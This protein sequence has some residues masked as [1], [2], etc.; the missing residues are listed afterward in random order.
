MSEKETRGRYNTCKKCGYQFKIVNKEKKILWEKRKKKCPNC[1]E[2]YCTMPETERTL[3]KLQDKYF[4]HDRDMQYLDRMSEIM[5]N[6]SQSLIKKF[7]SKYIVNEGDLEYYSQCTVSFLI[8]EYY[9]HEEYKVYASFAGALNDKI[10]QSLFNK[11]NL[12][13]EDLSLNWDFD[14]A[15]NDSNYYHVDKR[16]MKEYENIEEEENKIY[17]TKYILN[18][19]FGMSAYCNSKREDLIR[20][21]AFYLN[22][23]FGEK[24]AEKLF[25][26]E[27]RGKKD[28]ILQFKIYGR[29]NKEMYK[30]TLD[31]VKA[32]LDK[33][34]VLER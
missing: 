30:K 2:K 23:E 34:Y 33:L 13:Q 3:M 26:E 29:R 4:S 24:R 17:L 27:V 22:L 21:M 28:K 14:D 8:E 12:L 18:L 19:V 6:Y 31:V 25:Q 11:Y 7:Y 32:E 9:A 10:R 16:S 15:H 20:L 5:L 1:R